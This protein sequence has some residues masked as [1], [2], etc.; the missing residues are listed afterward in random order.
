MK[1]NTNGTIL[2]NSIIS[3]VRL[4]LTSVCGLLSTRFALQALG[5]T[6]FGLFSLIGSMISFIAIFNTIM[7]STSNRFI[8]VAIG[9]GDIHNTNEQFN[10]ML[11]I[12]AL[13]A[14]TT[15]ILGFIIGYWYIFN[16][17]NFDGDINDA[18]TVFVFTLIGSVVS[19]IGIPYNGLLMAREN[20]IVFSMTEVLSHIVKTFIAFL[21]IFYF[22]EK[23]LI[24]TITQCILMAT[25]TMVYF[26]YCKCRYPDIVRFHFVRQMEKF[27]PVFSFSS[28]VAVGAFANIGKTQGAAMIVN[29]FFNTAMNAALGVANTVNMLIQLA[30]NNIWLPMAPQITKSYAANDKSRCEELLVMSTKYTYLTILFI[31]IPFLSDAKWIFTIWL[32][33]VPPYLVPFTTL[34][35]IDTLA[36]SLNLGVSSVIFASGKIKTYQIAISLLRLLS[37][38]FAF[39][40]LRDGGDAP[41]M[42][43]SYIAFTVVILIVTQWVLHKEL[44][45]D[46]SLLIRKSYIPSFAI[47]TL[48][49]PFFVIDWNIIPIVRIALELIWLTLLVFF[50][51]LSKKER[52]QCIQLGKLYL[53]RIK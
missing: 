36:G 18:L 40:I 45:Y 42:F 51:A 25:P 21:L 9:K 4:L 3:F 41:S 15:F 14:I 26:L 34:L 43:Y 28:W 29:A 38:V 7:V 46:N 53:S 47:T 10:I 11:T 19:F 5:I 16:Y 44:G 30:G 50:I 27:R 20:F 2:Y 13:I 17:V 33:N 49:I 22:E 8:S 31:S 12:H 32:G 23:L 52:T 35:I 6:D 48:L 37:V 1:E 24:Y 39:V